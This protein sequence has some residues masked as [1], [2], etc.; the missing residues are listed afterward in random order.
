MTR[1]CRRRVCYHQ[2]YTSFPGSCSMN[3]FI[4]RHLHQRE[5]IYQAHKNIQLSLCLIP[6]FRSV[7]RT[8]RFPPHFLC[9][10]PYAPTKQP[11]DEH[12]NSSTQS[13]IDH[14]TTSCYVQPS[15]AEYT[16]AALTTPTSGGEAD[17]GE[18][19]AEV[20][21][22]LLLSCSPVSPSPRW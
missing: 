2:R 16:H 12:K 6:A 13:S 18:G 21:C 10:P 1:Y 11:S 19:V 7:P 9:T 14:G 4:L 17:K 8:W 22:L 15:T 5:S 3:A 20:P